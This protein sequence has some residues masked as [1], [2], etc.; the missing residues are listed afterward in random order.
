MFE[1]HR[2]NKS[3]KIM[4]ATTIAVISGILSFYIF[5]IYRVQRKIA[6]KLFNHITV[7]NSWH[8]FSVLNI[9]KM[10]IGNTSNY[11]ETLVV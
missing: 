6:G 4:M 7:I 5:V 10:E 11:Q 8:I 3:V 9:F 1:E 2:H